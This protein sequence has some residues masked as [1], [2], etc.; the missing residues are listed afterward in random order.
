MIDRRDIATSPPA[1]I[2]Q[3]TSD[4]G[5]PSI[6]LLQSERDFYQTEY[7]KLLNRPT[8]V[9]GSAAHQLQL[10]QTELRTKD[11]LLQDLQHSVSQS[12]LTKAQLNRAERERTVQMADIEQLRCTCDELREQLRALSEEGARAEQ[13]RTEVQRQNDL[14]VGENRAL[15]ANGTALQATAE[16][17]RERLAEVEQ[18]RQAA[19]AECA[20]V[21]TSFEQM[22]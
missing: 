15:C 11:R 17:L 9:D 20:R 1:I 3:S 22:K 4:T 6:E 19:E 16:M 21:R 14:M 18:R 2:G 10:L 8:G 12:Q 7:V 13:Q 5:L